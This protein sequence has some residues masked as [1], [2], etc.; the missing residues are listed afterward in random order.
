MYIRKKRKKLLF[1]L[2]LVNP[3]INPST[4]DGKIQIKHIN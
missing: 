1:L 2:K 3:D 4:P